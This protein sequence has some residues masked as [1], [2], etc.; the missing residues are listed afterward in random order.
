[1]VW[2]KL[3]KQLESFLSESLVG[4]V[5]YLPSGYR[6]LPDKAPQCYITVDKFEVFNT[7]KCGSFFKWYATETDV[8]KDPSIEIVITALEIDQIKKDLHANVPEE[9]LQS[10]A[11][12][13]KLTQLAKK[14]YR[15]QE[16]L[17]KSDFQKTALNFL[18]DSIENSL[19][20]DDILVNVLA[21]MDRRVGKKRLLTL[22]NKMKMKHAIVRYFYDLRMN[23]K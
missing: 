11:K 18:S 4:K 19:E 3:K 17:F 21:I 23:E 12:T 16:K 15:E 14:I 9:K 2:N 10:I 22:K 8:K 13:R 20:C 7:N 6:Y 5:E 1:M